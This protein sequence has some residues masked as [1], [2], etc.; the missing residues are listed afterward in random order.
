[1]TIHRVQFVDYDTH[2]THSSSCLV[3]R[4]DVRYLCVQRCDA[5]QWQ[6]CTRPV[7]GSRDTMDAPPETPCLPSAIYGHTLPAVFYPF[8]TLPP[9]DV[10]SIRS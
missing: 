5:S 6:E 2:G 7:Q 10:R 1:M 9:G 8:E 3:T 4:R